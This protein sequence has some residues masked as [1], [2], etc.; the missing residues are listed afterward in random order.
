MSSDIHLLMPIMIAILCAKVV[1]ESAKAP[2]SHYDGLRVPD[3]AWELE[4]PCRLV[5][6]IAP[7]ADPTD[8]RALGPEQGHDSVT[9]EMRAPC[10]SATKGCLGW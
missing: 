8:V 10:E 3:V 6:H 2:S 7:V 5:V 4:P 1:G 9:A